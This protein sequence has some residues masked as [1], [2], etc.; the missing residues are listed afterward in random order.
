MGEFLFYAI[1]WQN[2]LIGKIYKRDSRYRYLPNYDNIEL[3]TEIG[4]PK[5]LVVT[6]Q[7]EWGELPKLFKE[8][9]ARDPDCK[10]NCRSN[11]DQLEIRKVR[12]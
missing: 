9:I 11:S 3:A 12:S 8:R 1:Y 4:L 2:I 6:P 10:N 7:L 5:A